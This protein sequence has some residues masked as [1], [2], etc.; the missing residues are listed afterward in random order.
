MVTGTFENDVLESEAEWEG[1]GE[2]YVCSVWKRREA[3]VEQWDIVGL[4]AP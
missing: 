4:I 3:K 1:P 2:L